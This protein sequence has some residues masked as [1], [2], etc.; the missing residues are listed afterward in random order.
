MS[1]LPTPGPRGLRLGAAAAAALIALTGCATNYNARTVSPTAVRTAA[2]I[3]TGVVES[4]SEVTIRPDNSQVGAGVGAVAGGIAG[5]QIGGDRAVNALGALGGA[6]VGGLIGNA[7]GR[8]AQ[9]QTGYA[10]IVRFD[11]GEVREIVQGPDVL[12]A[13][14]TP[15]NV[16]FRGDGAIVTPR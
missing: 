16:V 13:P 15:V 6:V 9:T 1:S 11:S 8:A 12:I 4:V 10:Y 14:G 5:S 7:A 2:P 3:R